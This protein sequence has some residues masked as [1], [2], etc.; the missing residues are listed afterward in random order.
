MTANAEPIFTAPASEDGPPAERELPRLPSGWRVVAGKELADHLASV[1]LYVLFLVLGAAAL[2]P[3]YFAAERIRAAADAAS[4][5]PSLF[6]YLFWLSPQGF[7]LLSV[8]QFVA[9]AA[10][11]VGLG[12]AFDAINGE[13]HDGTLPRL[14]SQPI[15]RDDV[16]NGKF[17]AGL[18]AISLVLMAVIG[19]ISAFGFI[20]LGIIPAPNEIIRL[21]VWFLFTIVY[22]ALWLA[23]GLLLSVVIRRA[24]T[25][26]LVGFGV[27]LFVAIPIFGP[28]VI[29]IIGGFIAPGTSSDQAALDAAGTQQ[30]LLRLLPSTL[31]QE[32]SIVILSPQ[33]STVTTPATIGQYDQLQQQIPGLASLDQSLLLVW[34]HIVTLIAL[35]AICFAAAYIRFM[36]QE[37]RA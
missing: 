22:V 3:M 35:T 34:P 16:I 30:F 18:A 17:V 9:M 23:F 2:I 36:R 32:G 25:S 26:A 5:T 15:H 28:L 10:P 14:L 31:Y 37:V 12:F 7:T 11:L 20:R 29:S 33:V 19:V 24:A 13:R 6:L 4:G 1:R 21:I 8:Y 27:W